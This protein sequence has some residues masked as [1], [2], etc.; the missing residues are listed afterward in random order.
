[1]VVHFGWVRQAFTVAEEAII[2]IFASW[3]LPR[4]DQ[5]LP[6]DDD[7]YPMI[8]RTGLT[9]AKR[10]F[11]SIGDDQG[12]LCDVLGDVEFRIMSVEAK[13]VQQLPTGL[14]T[15]PLDT[16]GA[17]AQSGRELYRHGDSNPGFRRERAAS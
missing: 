5:D 9:I 1:V 7:D 10:N 2:E 6:I 16:D 8:A 17:Q 4:G 14:P 3:F 15:R 13:A 11:Q 12:T